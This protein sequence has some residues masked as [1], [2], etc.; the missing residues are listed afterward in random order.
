M[1]TQKTK[2]WGIRPPVEQKDYYMYIQHWKKK[3][4]N[5]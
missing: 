5:S 2:T 3:K 4:Q 1:Y